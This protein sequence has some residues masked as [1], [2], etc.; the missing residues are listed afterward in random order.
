MDELCFC[1]EFEPDG[2]GVHVLD[3]KNK[4]IIGS[5]KNRFDLF[6][7]IKKDPANEIMWVAG[8]SGLYGYDSKINLV[9]SCVIH[10]P[11]WDKGSQDKTIKKN[12]FN[13]TCDI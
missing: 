12:S 7:V 2:H 11:F 3:I 13:F 1:N 8:S 9:R 10:Y 4:K 5:V 6:T